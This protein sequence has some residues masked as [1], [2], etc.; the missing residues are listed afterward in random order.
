MIYNFLFQV[1]SEEKKSG[2]L[3]YSLENPTKRAAI[4][5]GLSESTCRRYANMSLEPKER[6]P[7]YDQLHVDTFDRDVIRRTIHDMLIKG[8]TVPTAPTILKAIKDKMEFPGG[9]HYLRSILKEMGFEWKSCGSNRSVLMERS[10]VVVARIEFLRKMRQYR[11]EGRTIVY[12]DETFVHSSHSMKKCWQSD[13]MQL[14]IPFTRGDRLII[15]H[16]GSRQGFIDGACLMFKAKSSSGD[17][18]SEM[19]STNFFKWVKEKLVP[20]LP[21]NSVLV[22]DN[23]AYHNIQEDKC[24]TQSTRKAD[25]QSWLERHSVQFDPRMLKA[26]LYELCLKNKKSPVYILD[27]IL[28]QHGHTC[29]R[30]PQYHAELNAIELIWAMIKRKVAC[31][32]LTFKMKDVLDLTQ[33]AISSITSSDW[34]NCCRHVED[35]E[36][37]FIKSDNAMDDAIEKFIIEVTDEEGTDSASEGG[38]SVTDTASGGSE[39]ETASEC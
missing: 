28:Q 8:P 21:A 9:L 16:A 2:V 25:M 15:V 24:P 39:T 22:I 1:C 5:T 23:A 32:N 11:R 12:T 27:T 7:R 36:Q 34:E 38:E 14:K 4:Y 20:N 17:Y 13:D 18:H 29:I 26:E 37:R 33:D 30:L 10:D 31:Q 6:K 19:N 3:A 35:V